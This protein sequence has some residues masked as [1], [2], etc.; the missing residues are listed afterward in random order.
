MTN[1]QNSWDDFGMGLAGLAAIAG[2]GSLYIA[3]IARCG[4]IGRWW[5]DT[6]LTVH[7]SDISGMLNDAPTQ[8]MLMIFGLAAPL[9]MLWAVGYMIYTGVRVCR[10]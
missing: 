8:M 3:L 4:P 1:R 5:A 2:A 7:S 10:R 6:F 9:L